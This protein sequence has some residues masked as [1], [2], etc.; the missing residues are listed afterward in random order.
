MRSKL[1]SSA[2]IQSIDLIFFKFR[3]SERMP[4]LSLQYTAG[5][6]VSITAAASPCSCAS[7]QL[8]SLLRLLPVGFENIFYSALTDLL[9]QVM[10]RQACRAEDLMN[11]AL[12]PL[13]QMSNL[14][15]VLGNKHTITSRAEYARAQV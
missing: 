7:F 6:T 3:V 5:I 12:V 10:V 2:T 11:I 14:I 8:I 1:T 4:C 9:S 15:W 13:Q